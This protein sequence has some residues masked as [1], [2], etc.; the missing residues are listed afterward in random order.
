MTKIL[1]VDDHKMLR[2]ILRTLLNA[3]PGLEVV[4]DANDGRTGLRIAEEHQPD[5][6]ICDLRM[7]GMDGI[8]LTRELQAL[9]PPIRV[10]ILTM[11]GDPV[12]VTQALEAG[13]SA[14]I[15]KGTDISELIQ[16]IHEVNSGHRYLSPSLPGQESNQ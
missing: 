14:Y 7:D 12:Y 4:G 13:A 5:I 6:A 9:S 2:G 16:A 15:L 3:E 1:I 10:I 11:Y 8:E